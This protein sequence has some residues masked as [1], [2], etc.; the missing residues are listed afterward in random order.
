MGDCLLCLGEKFDP[1]SWRT[2][3]LLCMV[4]YVPKLTPYGWKVIC[5]T[6]HG[7]RGDKPF[8]CCRHKALE[9]IYSIGHSV[10]RETRWKLWCQ[11][12]ENTRSRQEQQPNPCGLL[13]SGHVTPD[14]GVHIDSKSRVS[15]MNT[16][17]RPVILKSHPG[18]AQTVRVQLEFLCWELERVE[19][20][21][22]HIQWTRS[23]EPKSITYYVL[24]FVTHGAV[25]LHISADTT[26]VIWKPSN[27]WFGALAARR[28]CMSPTRWQ[29]STLKWLKTLLASKHGPAGELMPIT[30]LMP[31]TAAPISSPYTHTSCEYLER[32]LVRGTG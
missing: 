20:P 13:Q 31:S 25:R 21:V 15:F 12:W 23:M 18:S 17:R 32:Y 27:S 30:E 8:N 10:L 3:K 29:F 5:E 22:R 1:K 24:S 26:F 7:S 19:V 2:S 16:H 4:E 14:L 28:H 11:R 6:L 9:N